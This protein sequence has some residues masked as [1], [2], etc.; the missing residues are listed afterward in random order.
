MIAGTHLGRPAILRE[1]RRNR[2]QCNHKIH[3]TNPSPACAE[4]LPEDALSPN[5][6]STQPR[7]RRPLPQPSALRYRCRWSSEPCN[8]NNRRRKTKQ[9]YV[10]TYIFVAPSQPG[11]HQHPLW[12]G[13][14]IRHETPRRPRPDFPTK[15][16][17]HPCSTWSPP[18]NSNWISSRAEAGTTRSQGRFGFKIS[19]SKDCP[20]V[21]APLRTNAVKNTLPNVSHS[22]VKDAVS[23]RRFP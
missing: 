2:P 12:R 4:L 1:P 15:P 5:G 14:S 23:S 17:Q 16:P 7:A 11:P 19:T 9:V 10:D 21:A 20:S 8:Q 13:N 18:A 3:P 22:G 6:R